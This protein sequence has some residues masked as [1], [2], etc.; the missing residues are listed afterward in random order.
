MPKLSWKH[1]SGTS[2]YYTIY[3]MN[4]IICKKGL[5]KYSIKFSSC[6]QL[7]TIINYYK[8]SEKTQI[9]LADDELRWSWCKW[10]KP[11]FWTQ[12]FTTIMRALNCKKHFQ[13]N[14]ITG[15][16]ASASH[17]REVNSYTSLG[18]WVDGSTSTHGP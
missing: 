13:L 14:C 8:D 7:I 6:Q 10:L 12:D 17:G 5:M 4:G 1:K 18:R 9:R 16:A 3:K 15:F 11:V 2:F